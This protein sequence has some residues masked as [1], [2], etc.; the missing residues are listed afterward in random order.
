[1][2]SSLILKTELG[3]ETHPS[4]YRLSGMEWV[5]GIKESR[6]L[7][8][9]R[10]FAAVLLSPSG[11]LVMTQESGLYYARVLRRPSMW[12]CHEDDFDEQRA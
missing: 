2:R 9:P 7:V 12:E 11:L 8:E 4:G 6:F 5:M 10:H 1:M 3:A